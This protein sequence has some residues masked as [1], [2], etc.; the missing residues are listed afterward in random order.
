ML[1]EQKE[2]GKKNVQAI[3]TKISEFR[4]YDKS[5]SLFDKTRKLIKDS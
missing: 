1:K 4:C 5:E 2:R 3:V